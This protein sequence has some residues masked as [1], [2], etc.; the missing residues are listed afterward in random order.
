MPL[1]KTFAAAAAGEEY[2][3]AISRDE[4]AWVYESRGEPARAREVRLSR[5]ASGLVCSHEPCSTTAA[6]CGRALK[7]CSK[8]HAV[9]Y[10]G[11]DC[12]KKAWKAGHKAVCTEAPPP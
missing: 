5:G 7:G 3:A 6:R 10:C 2:D 9:W 11:P 8:C 12:Q 4:L 1:L